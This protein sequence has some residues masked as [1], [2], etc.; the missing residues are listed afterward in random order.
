M[1]A[2]TISSSTKVLTILEK[3]RVPQTLMFHNKY[4]AGTPE[5]AYAIHSSFRLN[6]VFAAK[7][8]VGPT[9]LNSK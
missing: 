8:S 4:P 5:R 6:F 9:I 1:F 7:E 2:V 3:A